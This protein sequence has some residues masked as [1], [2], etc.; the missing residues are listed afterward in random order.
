MSKMKNL[1]Y[2]IDD[3]ST[4][5]DIDFMFLYLNSELKDKILQIKEQ[6]INNDK[7]NDPS[8]D[9]ESADE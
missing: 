9:E 1:I 5:L 6:Y 2:D 7:D 3:T 4:L 8:D